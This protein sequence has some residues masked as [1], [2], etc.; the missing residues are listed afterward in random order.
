LVGVQAYSRIGAP[1]NVGDG[2]GGVTIVNAE[3]VG[4]APVS[5][6]RIIQ[7]NLPRDHSGLSL[8]I[9][10]CISSCCSCQMQCCARSSCQLRPLL[11]KQSS[12]RFCSS[13]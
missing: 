9:S 6:Y 11:H 10:K 12:D 13:R 5:P 4:I 8:I 1:T 3:E 7:N 2:S